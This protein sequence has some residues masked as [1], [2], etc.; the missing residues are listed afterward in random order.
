MFATF[1]NAWKIA[2]LRRKMLFTVMVILLYR[3]GAQIPVPYV[4]ASLLTSGEAFAG[5]IFEYLNWFSGDAFGKATLFAL[6]VSPYI[7]AQIIIQLLTVAI[8]ALERLAKEGEEGQRLLKE[9]GIE[10]GYEGIGNIIIG[11]ADGKA[12]EAAPRLDN[13]VITI[14]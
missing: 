2:D 14:E 12:P 3:L 8:P 4:T 13:R 7:T 11:F 6:S 10:E 5:S 9:W 1:K